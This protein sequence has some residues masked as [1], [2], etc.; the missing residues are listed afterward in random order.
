MASSWS[1][2]GLDQPM[3]RR[4]P[5]TLPSIEEMLLALGRP[6]AEII[7]DVLDVSPRTV[8]RWIRAG[9]AP[10]AAALA[11]YW[12]T[13][14]GRSEISKDMHNELMMLH[15]LVRAQ[16]DEISRLSEQL[17]HLVAIG[18]FGAANEPVMRAR[19]T[20]SDRKPH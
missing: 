18:E 20:G 11:I 7:G 19:G 4:T 10:R 17:E 14:H 16:R 12:M 8:K 6:S 9:I 3:I 5:K 1:W 13:N 2:F 15:G